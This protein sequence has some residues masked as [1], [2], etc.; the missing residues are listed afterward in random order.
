MPVVKHELPSSW[1]DR[2]LGKSLI[3]A[4][5][6]RALVDRGAQLLVVPAAWVA[7]ERKVDHWRTLVRAR[8]I[9]NQVYV[10]AAGQY[11]R[12]SEKRVCYGHSLIVDPWGTVV[13]EASDGE[14]VVVAEIDPGFQD[15][16]RRELPVLQLAQLPDD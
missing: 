16:V 5:L 13:A 2:W 6:A 7:G 1:H 11:G 4:G 14:G 9:E 3:V 10:L 15:K 8:A 12:T